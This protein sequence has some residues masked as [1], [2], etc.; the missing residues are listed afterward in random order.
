[1]IALICAVSAL[2]ITVKASAEEMKTPSNLA[3][4][5]I[6]DSIDSYITEREAGL[7]SC[8]V[9]VFDANGI[10]YNGCYGYSDIENNIPADSETVYEWGS[11]SKLLVWT[12]V[13][14]QW[15]QGNLDLNA[16]IREYL[17]ENFLTKLQYPEEKITM[18]NLMNHNAG[19]Q[20]SFYENQEASPDEVYDT[21]EEAV[22]N[23]ECYQAYHVGEYTAYSN[24]STSLAAYI[25]E[26]VSGTDYVTYVNE[27]I[28]APLGM[29]HT[30]IDPKMSD[31]TWVAS[32]RHELKCYARYED[33]KY[34]ED[35]DECLYGI[36]LFPAGAATGTLE[37]FSAFAQ[38]FVMEDCP[39][40][41]NNGT[42]E[43]MF[44]A[45]SYYGDSDIIKNAHGLWTSEYK[46]QTLGHGGNTG[47]CSSNLVFD[48][49]SGIGV[50]VMTNECG[51]TTFNYGIPSLIFGDVTE[52]EEFQNTAVSQNTDIS[53]TYFPKRAIV[54]GAAKAGSY[55]GGLMPWSKNKYGT[56][57]MK[58]FGFQVGDAELIPLAEHQYVM[59]DNGRNMFM[60]I[61]NNKLEMM[62]T[63]YVK[64]SVR[65]AGIAAVYGFIFLGI[66]CLAAILIKLFAK[67]KYTS[68]DKQILGQQ[69]V[70]AVS[71]IILVLFIM[72]IGAGSPAFTSFS[73]IMALIT[74]LVSLANGGIL[75]Y[76]TIKADDMKTG[77]KIK[78][79]IWSGL[80]IAYFIF[81]IMFQLYN[82]WN[83]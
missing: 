68:A 10:I 1:M 52:R 8:E 48:P 32:K 42:R 74:G 66:C 60:Y 38:A 72:I 81:I 58:L 77:T 40:F 19:F 2:N 20:E 50:V 80:G 7:A 27:N 15:E 71:S 21:L 24:W 41:E 67:R 6:K 28:F 23:C 55:T 33:P 4:S 82:F 73:G 62:S 26:Q 75:C 5:E 3:Y 43:E 12:S 70:Y 78:Q 64:N 69:G 76:N 79:F 13:M 65:T 53:G 45:T 35:Y 11:C 61:D 63:D 25:I 44:T 34:N 16:D 14:Q 59:K 54:S 39:L 30:C 83:L 51:E 37:D 18:L 49:E 57:S 29:E 56:Y 17:P 47:G 36:Q 31:N 9:S 46:I 22:K